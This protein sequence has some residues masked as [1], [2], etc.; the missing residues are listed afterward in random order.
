MI[1]N[2]TIKVYAQILRLF[3]YRGIERHF[4]MFI[5]TLLITLTFSFISTK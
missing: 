5:K 4:N 1:W 3:G 2:H